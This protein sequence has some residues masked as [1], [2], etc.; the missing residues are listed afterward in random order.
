[1][2]SG[3]LYGLNGDHFI[4]GI[5]RNT[6]ARR[7]KTI[8]VVDD[9]FGSPTWTYRLAQQLN[10]LIKVDAKGTYHATSEGYCNR[11]EYAQYVFHAMKLKI[12]VD[13][14]S[15][16]DF[17]VKARRPMNCILENRLLKKQGINIMPEWQ[18]DLDLFLGEFG[19][20][21]KKRAK[22]KKK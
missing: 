12:R 5:L 9:Q 16:R 19:E 20:E 22:S 15:I 3:W 4:T 8:K 18:A 11:Y 7:R 13:P 21:V 14:C 2:R 1:V 6:V 17:P 10:E